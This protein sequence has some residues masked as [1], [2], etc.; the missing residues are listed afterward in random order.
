MKAQLFGNRDHVNLFTVQ[1]VP[2][3]G[4]FVVSPVLAVASAVRTLAGG[5]L[6]IVG[7]IHQAATGNS[8]LLEKGMTH[9][10]G[11]ALNLAYSL[12]NVATLG[13]FGGTFWVGY[14]FWELGKA[15]TER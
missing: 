9:L 4:A 2:F 15:I 11:G 12:A 10:R 6:A 7:K 13:I 5:I 1:A 14:H 3:V 8:K